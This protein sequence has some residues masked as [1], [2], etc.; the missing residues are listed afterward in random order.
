MVDDEHPQF[1]QENIKNSKLINV[2]EGK[3][4]LH[5]KYAEEFNKRA[6]YFL[7]NGWTLVVY[8]AITRIAS[9]GIDTVILFF[10]PLVN[11][12]TCYNL[13]CFCCAI[14][15]L[16][17]VRPHYPFLYYFRLFFFHSW[18]ELLI[19]WLHVFDI[20]KICVLVHQN[21]LS[22]FRK[23]WEFWT[24]GQ[25]A[26]LSLSLPQSR[27]I[28]SGHFRELSSAIFFI[29]PFGLWTAPV[30]SQRPKAQKVKLRK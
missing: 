6:K 18:C 19:K 17:H 9:S 29:Q 20:L 23:T 8:C 25:S 27:R 22:L 7:L 3:H 5:L 16:L 14:A 15:I 21:E 26:D 10:L 12:G 11:F 30:E 2:T 4:N 28:S 24:F 13:A 1:L